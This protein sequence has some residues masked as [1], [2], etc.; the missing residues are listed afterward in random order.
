VSEV[1]LS[2]KVRSFLS[3]KAQK[4]WIGGKW[5]PAADGA[6]FA[7][8]NPATGGTLAKVASAGAV[9]VDRAVRAARHAFEDGPWSQMSAAERGHFLYAIADA[10]EVDQEELAQLESLDNGKPITA[11]RQA[12]IRKSIAYFRYYAGWPTK[13]TGDTVPVSSPGMFAY[14]LRQPVG[15]CGQ[16]IPWNYPLMMA[17][18]KLAPA[19]AAGCTTVLKPAEQTPLSALYLARIIESLDLP[20]GVVNLVTGLG[21][22]AGAAL[23]CHP[24]VDKLA[25]TGSTEVGRSIL[26]A[27]ADSNLKRVSLELGGKSPNIIFADANLGQALLGASDGIFSNMGQDCTAGSRVFVERAAYDDF[28]VALGERA[29]ALR[30]GPGL[31]EATEIGPLVSA[32][33]LQ[34]V[35]GYIAAGESEGARLVAGGND[36]NVSV[37][38]QGFF[39]R[40]TVFADVEN[41][42]RIAQEEIFGP[43]VA[44][45]PFRSIDE[46]IKLANQSPY[47]LAAGVWTRDL[48]KAHRLTA[49]L[50]AGIVWVNHYGSSVVELP[51]GGFKQSGQGREHG[52][53]GLLLYTELKSVMVNIA[54][55]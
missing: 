24:D 14:T 6:V 46:V 28:T 12:D 23:A 54:A 17:S 10:M 16:I 49:A 42:M 53:E 5:V 32:E 40:P 27:S 19:L 48:T 45:I 9:D 1:K 25:F 55:D 4:L 15:V 31:D 44:V 50:Q 7:S 20:P 34:R 2:P 51:F 52:I 11:A 29:T 3:T 33:Q 41:S 30:V 22:T 43:V 35:K 26:R 38:E 47:G 39:A 37:S 13:L 21:E 18:W 36:V 8:L